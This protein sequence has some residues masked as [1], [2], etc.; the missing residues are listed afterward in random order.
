MAKR[1][2]KGS[3][4]RARKLL[5]DAGR[6]ELKGLRLAESSSKLGELRGN[7]LPGQAT[8]AISLSLSLT[9]D[10]KRE[11]VNVRIKLDA[12]YDGDAT[13]EPAVSILA[14]FMIFFDIT[15]EFRDRAAMEEFFQRVGM[16]VVWPYWRE[17]VQ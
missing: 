13:K 10:E 15:E 16:L 17:F 6:V 2:H 9:E 11:M 8:Q 14:S 12:S 7:D 4:A 3:L 1:A 5:S